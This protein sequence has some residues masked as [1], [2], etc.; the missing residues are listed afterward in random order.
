VVLRFYDANK[1][2]V[3]TL[4]G[5]WSD[6]AVG[7][8]N[9][10]SDPYDPAQGS[11]VISDGLWSAAFDGLAD[12]GIQLS[13]GVYLVEAESRD[14]GGQK[15]LVAANL[16]I[17]N[18]KAQ[19]LMASAWPNPA[20]TGDIVFISWLPPVPVEVIIYN[21]AGERIS[22]LGLLNPPPYATW[23][24]KSAS[25]Q[26]VASGIYLAVLRSPSAGVIGKVKIV[27]RK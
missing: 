7:L 19:T 13:N 6:H 26:D 15:G 20:N 11:L 14:A 17:L 24:L 1:M 2:V 22:M 10:S 3:R 21:V 4:D 18:G 8:L 25:G 9:F 12:N 23:D 27:V 16:T 5:G